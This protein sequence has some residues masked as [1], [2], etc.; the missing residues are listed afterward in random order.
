MD[1][2]QIVGIITSI[3][4]IIAL[5]IS[6]Y[7]VIAS[8]YQNKITLSATILHDL[9]QDF[10]SDNMKKI[11]LEAAT[12]A[13]NKLNSKKQKAI[14]SAIYDVLDFFDHLG[15]YYNKKIVEKEMTWVMFY[16]WLSFYWFIL[17]AEKLDFEKLNGLNYHQN[18]DKIFKK[19]L[20]IMQTK[21][22]SFIKENYFTEERVRIFLKD[23]IEFC[24]K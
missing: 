16:Y 18:G 5:G 1:I 8:S 19:L 2:N 11:R 10:D 23:E 20:S 6:L 17:K 12:F 15:V 4:S 9:R 3:T 21:N 24:R 13:L 14:P 22:K 7:G